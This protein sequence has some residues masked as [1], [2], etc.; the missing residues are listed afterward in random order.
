MLAWTIGC[1]LCF[2][3]FLFGYAALKVPDAKFSP[4]TPS[5][6]EPG[7]MLVT[8]G[9]F[10]TE[11]PDGAL[12]YETVRTPGFPLFYGALHG[13]LRVPLDGV[14]LI[15]VLLTVISGIMVYRAAVT[16]DVRIGI[17]SAFIALFDLPIT[18]YSLMLLTETLYLF[19][20]AIF[21]WAFLSYLKEKRF[22]AL[23]YSA[24]ALGA[25]T[26]VRPI[27]YY[28]G[29]ASAFFIVYA[30]GRKNP[31]KILG[32]AVLFFIM[33]YALLGAWQYRNYQRT[34][35]AIFSGIERSDLA[36]MGLWKSYARNDDP[37][38][39]GMAPLPYYVN[40]SAR[41]LLSLMTIPGTLKYLNSPLLKA[42]GK[43]AGYPW[44][45]FW[46][47]GFL[48]G[49]VRRRGDKVYQFMLMVIGYLIVTSIIG[50]GL[51]VGSRF[52]IP[53]MPFIAIISADGWQ[54]LSANAAKRRRA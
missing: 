11:A 5:Y 16:V 48:I 30:L 3:L 37:K 50:V 20:M 19:F 12:R 8:R 7:M 53:M 36:A 22:S 35:D 51:C 9:A 29:A 4:D 6:L 28:L 44:V 24:I 45:A 18:I 33:V 27:S 10:A 43:I 15:Q 23:I 42:A 31:R 14:V 25:A 26:F 41:S 40:V 32:H 13:L 54:W 47:A 46:M 38:T 17:L 34:G 52:R 49:A 2:K 1:A 21:M 39:Q